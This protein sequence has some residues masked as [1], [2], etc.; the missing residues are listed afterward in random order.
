MRIDE[1]VSHK[2]LYVSRKLLN[3]DD[4]VA[5]AKAQGL[6]SMLNPEELHVTICYSKSPMSWDIE[7]S[8]ESVIVPAIDDLN[9]DEESER[10]MDMFGKDKNVLVLR[11]ECPDL[12]AR[13]EDFRS[14]GAS[15]DFPEYHA[16]ITITYNGSHLNKDDLTPYT[17]P[18]EFGP[19]IF[20]EIS[21]VW[22][23]EVDEI[24]LTKEITRELTESAEQLPKKFWL[25]INLP[26]TYGEPEE[27]FSQIEGG[28]FH[29]LK[30]ISD[31]RHILIQFTRGALFVMDP[32]AVLAVND[33]EKFQY[34]D[35]EALVRNNMAMLT[36]LFDRQQNPKGWGGTISRICDHA[37]AVYQKLDFQLGH[38]WSYY[39]L[40]WKAGD[41]YENNPLP[42]ETVDDC[43]RAIFECL[44]GAAR[45]WNKDDRDA[46]LRDFV[47][48]LNYD[49]VLQAVKESLATIGR[50]YSNEGEWAVKSPSFTVPEGSTLLI[51]VS[52]ED[53]EAYR[54][55]KETPDDPRWRWGMADRLAR[56]EK[57]QRLLSE[58]PGIMRRYN[59]RFVDEPA[60]ARAKA[61]FL[62][63]RYAS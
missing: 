46:R 53:M 37:L 4:I 61:A 42:I 21:K 36:R 23:G 19:E 26:V 15:Y 2:P 10:G 62:K 41:V 63:R 7:G 45:H 14:H 17:G 54:Q 13:H 44:K 55:S 48:E 56:V 12:S 24:D 50:T 9:E 39:N 32:A 33:L 60:L 34:N 18:L 35:A 57:L 43:S 5:W 58:H 28:E 25:S 3:G 6:K 52:K 51:I 29:G 38:E 22:A 59:V 47:K 20:K 40:G 8:D 49:Y 30:G 16:H 1:V 27:A 11:F 31:S